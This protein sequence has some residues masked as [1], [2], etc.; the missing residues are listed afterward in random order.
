MARQ[1]K[2][3]IQPKDSSTPLSEYNYVRIFQ[4]LHTHHSFEISVPFDYLEG[5][6]AGFMQKAHRE[7]VGKPITF[8]LTPDATGTGGQ[9]AFTGFVTDLVVA[10]DNDYTGS[11]L[12][13]GY[14]PT[15][16]LTDGVQKRTFV[17]QTLE[18]IIGQVLQPYRA[19]LLPTAKNL[20]SKA[21][22]PYVV[23]YNESN[24]DFLNR[25]MA[26]C[27]EWFFYDGAKLQFGLPEQGGTVQLEMNRHWSSFQLE[28][29]I[30]PAKVALHSYDP[31]QHQH[32]DGK[33]PATA[34]GISANQF[35]Q[36]ALQT[37]NDVFA[38]PSHARAPL[39]VQSRNEVEEAAKA[40]GAAL[41][42]G[43]LVFRG[44]S[45]N[46]DLR[47]GTLIDASAEGLGSDNLSVD[48][49]GKYRI[50]SLSHDVDYTGSYTNTFTAVLHSLELPP[51]NP[52]ARPQP[53]LPELA[54]VIDVTDPQKIGRVRVRYY[55]PVDKPANAETAWVRV[56]TPY[57]GDGKG[58][59]FTPEVG[60]QV[61]VH[62][63]QHRAEQPV[64]LGNLFHAQNKQGAKYTNPQ[65]N[66][67]GLQTAGGNKFVMADAQGEQKILISNSNNKGTA[68]EVG[69]KGDGSITIKSNGPVTVLGSTI[70]LEAGDK[71]EIYM[72]AKTVTV[73]A[74]EVLRL[75]SNTK[76]V[77]MVA[78]EKLAY[79]GRE[80][81]GKAL[82]KMSLD[83]GSK[84]TTD[85]ADSQYL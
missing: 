39:P 60:S 33:S 57:A 7:L 80:V 72:H 67:K 45:E 62:Y 26:E 40:A 20:K 25:L 82:E 79:Q 70:T 19:N 8:S 16:L 18:G 34:S 55:W 11:F 52:H 84:L 47:L 3:I 64:V 42:A 38:Q 12:I 61:L 23:Q 9:F 73:E 22:L 48:S 66:L 36:F 81:S 53:G 54:E 4:D 5:R 28:A 29:A 85:S 27:H 76:D 32:W 2:L 17:N 83:G 10:S 13:R 68:V 41:A 51:A 15:C 65:N 58:Q 1:V 37:S 69:F 44:R 77:E 35:A 75:S 31:A 74:E 46:P 24:F 30:R 59:L 49:L 56:L 50:V 63:E 43:S 71:G 78:K 14:S 6:T 21:T